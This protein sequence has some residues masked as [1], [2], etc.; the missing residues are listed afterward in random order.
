VGRKRKGRVLDVYVGSSKVGRYSLE[1]SGRTLLRYDPEWLSS[2]RAFPVSL[3]MP[4]SDRVWLGE[5]ATTYFDGLLPN[6]RT[7]REKIAAH[8]QAESAGIF[9][10]LAV[11]G[12]VVWGRCV[13][14]PRVLILT[15]RRT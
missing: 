1:P 9:D 14:F 10:L 15:I 2:E 8:E 13:F 6:D 5:S 12:L 4:L 7:V 11:I 3:S